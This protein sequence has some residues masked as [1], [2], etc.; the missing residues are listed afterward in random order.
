MCDGLFFDILTATMLS[1]YSC[2]HRC[3]KMKTCGTPFH[4]ADPPKYPHLWGNPNSVRK[5]SAKT[6]LG[7]GLSLEVYGL[8]TGLGV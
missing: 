8:L 5:F 4:I 1:S 6:K 7:D 2:L 3:Q